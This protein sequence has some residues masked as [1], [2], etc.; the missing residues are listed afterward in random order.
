V[1]EL[2]NKLK[3]ELV[4]ENLLLTKNQ[5]KNK[6]ELLFKLKELPKKKTDQ[7]KSKCDSNTKN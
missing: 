7:T 2:K 1:P 4:I 3:E 5:L 6:P